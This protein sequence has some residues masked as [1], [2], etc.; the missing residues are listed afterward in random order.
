M[1]TD[2]RTY[3]GDGG[4]RDNASSGWHVQTYLSTKLQAVS[5][6]FV[7]ADVSTEALVVTIRHRR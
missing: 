3:C 1:N 2:F 4:L 6:S 5:R 7:S